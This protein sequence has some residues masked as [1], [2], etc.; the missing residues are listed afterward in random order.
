MSISDIEIYK[1]RCDPEREYRIGLV[2]RLGVNAISDAFRRKHHRSLSLTHICGSFLKISDKLYEC[3]WWY[4]MHQC[5]RPSSNS[6]SIQGRSTVDAY[7]QLLTILYV[8][9]YSTATFTRVPV[10]APGGKKVINCV[11]HSDVRTLSD[12]YPWQS[13]SIA[14]SCF[15]TLKPIMVMNEI[16]TSIGGYYLKQKPISAEKSMKIT[17]KIPLRGVCYCFWSFRRD[18]LIKTLTSSGIDASCLRFFSF[19]RD[20]Y[21]SSVIAKPFLIFLVNALPEL[22]NHGFLIHFWYFLC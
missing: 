19:S 17:K 7:L 16:H 11:N 4:R 6:Y 22:I 9:L 14:L 10:P 15:V 3:C 21:I 18:S 8:L 20:W 5:K 1:F 2:T 12:T 13:A